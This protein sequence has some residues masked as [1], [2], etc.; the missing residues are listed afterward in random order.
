[1]TH[2]RAASLHVPRLAAVVAVVA[3][4]ACGSA[5]DPDLMTFSQR[6]TGPNEFLV[7]PVQPLETPPQAGALPP[8][9][10][11]LANRADATP[12]ED[13][14]AALGG[15]PARVRPTGAIPSGDAGLVNHA[16]RLGRE[17]AIRQTL[18]QED[19]ETRRQ[20]RGRLLERM[21]NQNRYYSAY[22][23]QRLDQQAETDRFRRAGL[24]TP[25]A[26]PAGLPSE[27]PEALQG[28]FGSNDN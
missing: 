10:P 3:V 28:I 14:V 9:T 8:P 4:S 24:P 19:L 11:G 7:A 23:R 27:A 25:S 21:V 26:P 22:E 15:N 5:G 20:N 13:A 6:S 18:A 17:P 16:S 1:M 2:R 12:M